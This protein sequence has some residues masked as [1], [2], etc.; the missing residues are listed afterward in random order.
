MNFF[1]LPHN[2][3]H[4]Y[5]KINLHVSPTDPIP[6]SLAYYLYEIKEK[7]KDFD[8]EWDIYKEYT[9]PYEYIHTRVPNKRPIAQYKPLSRSYFKM[10]EIIQH[11][12]LL[13]PFHDRPIQTFHL[14]EGPGGF[15]EAL[16]QSREKHNIGL[17]SKDRV[18]GMTLLNEA[19]KT[20]PSW[21]KSHHFL[22]THPNVFI[23]Y[24]EDGRGDLL[25]IENFTGCVKKYA[26]QMDF[27]TADGGFDF[28]EDFNRQEVNILPLL[29]AQI[30]FAVCM[31]RKGGVFVLKIFDCF[32][33][34]TVELIY[35]L[36]CFYEK[37]YI[38]KPQTSRFANSEKYLVC[39]NFHF[40]SCIDYYPYLWNLLKGYLVKEEGQKEGKEEG[41]KEE[42]VC[43]W[44]HLDK[45][46]SPSIPSFNPPPTIRHIFSFPLPKYFMSK[47]EEY[48]MVLGQQQIDTIFATILLMDNRT[49]RKNRIEHYIQ[50]HTVKC[51]QWCNR[52]GI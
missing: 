21:K 39:M 49:N 4:E 43:R 50:V 42:G 51:M 9:N 48:N 23:E 25:S 22:R 10:I 3:P 28:S 41:Q 31:Q 18:I 34:P 52:H 15:I 38:T 11:F 27:I 26:S 35:L 32:M 6:N 45:T 16:V 8:A 30:C 47:L 13:D 33:K 12:R 24:G 2:H 17:A 37:V 5:R 1:L 29:V 7:I 20:I 19:D 14:A 44:N 40:D 36:S 46:S